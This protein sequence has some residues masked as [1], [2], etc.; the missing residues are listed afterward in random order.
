MAHMSIHDMLSFIN[1]KI[2]FE[3]FNICFRCSKEPSHWG[4]PFKHPQIFS[5]INMKAKFQLLNLLCLKNGEILPS[6]NFYT[7]LGAQ[8]N[9]LMEMTPQAPTTSVFMHKL[10]WENQFSFTQKLTNTFFT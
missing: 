10:T 1:K 2:D 8:K 7:R 6:T 3:N 5:I 9:A 4:D